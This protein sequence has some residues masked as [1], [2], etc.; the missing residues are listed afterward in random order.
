MSFWE[1][2]RSVSRRTHLFVTVLRAYLPMLACAAGALNARPLAPAEPLWLLGSWGL[3]Y[4]LLAWR[5]E[6]KVQTIEISES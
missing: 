6:Q 3:I 2:R 1:D 5:I 4:L